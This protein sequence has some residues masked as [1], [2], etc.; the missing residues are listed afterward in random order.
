MIR[1]ARSPQL[2]NVIFD[3]DG[4]LMNTLE[5][6]TIAANS[7]IHELD[8]FVKPC[9]DSQVRAMV[10]DGARVLMKKMLIHHGHSEPGMNL[11][12]IAHELFLK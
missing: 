1:L 10:G 4:T 5:D 7:A 9:S 8:P 11:I 12:S 6:I 3:L 2:W